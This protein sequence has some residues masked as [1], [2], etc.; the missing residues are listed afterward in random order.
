MARIAQYNGEVQQIESLKRQEIWFC[1]AYFAKWEG[2][3][4]VEVENLNPLCI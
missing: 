2:R 4:V 1:A 3:T